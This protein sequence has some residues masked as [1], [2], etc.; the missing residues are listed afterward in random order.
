MK[1]FK[2]KSLILALTSAAIIASLAILKFQLQRNDWKIVKN[3]E[4]DPL[5]FEIKEYELTSK[6]EKEIGL[7]PPV[8]EFSGGAVPIIKEHIY[9]VAKN[10]STL[11]FDSWSNL[12]RFLYENAKYWAVRVSFRSLNSFGELINMDKLF[13]IQN[14]EIKYSF[15]ANKFFQ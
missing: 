8:I 7:R 12:D 6:W 9:K 2:S 5:R 10:P 3:E 11:T 4:T 15:E 1:K 13:L 14:K